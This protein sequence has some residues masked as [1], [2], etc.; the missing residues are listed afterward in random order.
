MRM[1][2]YLLI[3][4]TVLT[5]LVLFVFA[6]GCATEPQL[7][8]L[9]NQVEANKRAIEQLT[10]AVNDARQTLTAQATQLALLSQ[11]LSNSLTQTSLTLQKYVQDY[12]NAYLQALA[13]K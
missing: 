3:W 10:Q 1:K 5:V 8:T 4:N 2:G 9:A 7:S 6:R 11:S 13:P 12:V